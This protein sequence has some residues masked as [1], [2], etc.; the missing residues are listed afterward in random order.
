MNCSYYEQV[1]NAYLTG[2]IDGPEWRKHLSEC[3]AC[4]AKL[5][6]ES[7]FDLLVRHAVNEERVQTRQIEAHVRA[8]I[9]GSSPWN[10]PGFVMLRYAAAATVALATLLIATFG[11]ANGRME[12]NAICID[13]AEDHQEEIIGKARRKWRTEAKEV[14]A[15]SQKITGD[16]WVAQHLAPAG[17]SLVGARTCILHGKRYLHLNYSDGSHEVSL[18]VRPQDDQNTILGR[19]MHWFD[20]RGTEVEPVEG[21]TVGSARRNHVML[22]IVSSSPVAEVRKAIEM[23]ATQLK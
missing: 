11:Y 23:A 15:L 1:S 14:A 18:F 7:D 17:Y 3:P 2:E 20:F 19:A 5:R 10:R 8:A 6:E 9:R 4:A 22:V 12:Q 16:P 13:A 21:L